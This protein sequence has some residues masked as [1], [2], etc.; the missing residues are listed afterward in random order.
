MS[1]TMNHRGYTARIEYDERDDIFV[2]RVLGV[3]TIISFHG[4]TVDELRAE[5]K[6]AVDDYLLECEEKGIAP[7]KPASGKLLLRVPPEVHGQALVRAQA[8]GKSLNQWITELL[9]REVAADA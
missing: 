5:F 7:E 2:G 3:R 9:Q 8:S 1:S 6:Q 4:A